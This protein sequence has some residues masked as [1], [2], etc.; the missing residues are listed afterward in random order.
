[1]DLKVRSTTYGGMSYRHMKTSRGVDHATTVT[2]DL[3]AFDFETDLTDEKIPSGTVL[4]KITAS[5]K[6]GAYDD[7]AGDGRAT[8]VGLLLD[9][10]S[11]GNILA[12]GTAAADVTGDAVVAVMWEG[13][14]IEAELSDGNGLDAN[15]KTDLGVRF[16]WF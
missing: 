11:I 10:C 1:V 5:G 13:D 15:A 8:A 3:S 16:K 7:A 4:G 6:Y 9:D 14:I 12:A 2:L